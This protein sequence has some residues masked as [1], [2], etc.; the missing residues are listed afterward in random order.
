MA[1][2][3]L[4]NWSK[5]LTQVWNLELT[6]SVTRSTPNSSSKINKTNKDLI[7]WKYNR[8]KCPFGKDC[9]FQHKCSFCFAPNHPSYACR[10]KD[11]R[12]QRSNGRGGGSSGG[13][14]N[15]HRHSEN[16]GGGDSSRKK[17]GHKE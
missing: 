4:R 3:P 12:E 2:N 10:R 11:R 7:C 9:T 15:D 5:T 14:S 1:E 13:S 17:K 16:S 8:G 6:D